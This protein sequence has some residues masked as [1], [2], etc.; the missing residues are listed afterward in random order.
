MKCCLRSVPRFVIKLPAAEWTTALHLLRDAIRF[1]LRA[2]NISAVK[3]YTTPLLAKFACRVSTVASNRYANFKPNFCRINEN[4]SSSLAITALQT[5]VDAPGLQIS[6][7]HGGMIPHDTAPLPVGRSSASTLDGDT[8]HPW[9]DGA[10]SRS[11]SSLRNT[12]NLETTFKNLQC[13]RGLHI[14]H[15]ISEYQ[16][17]IKVSK[18]R[19]YLEAV[20]ILY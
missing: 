13:L 15:H 1:T 2:P 6:Y 3:R 11:E 8:W 10:L 12:P 14:G 20:W 19:R 18:S 7:F 9:T 17:T 16:K 5:C 4:A